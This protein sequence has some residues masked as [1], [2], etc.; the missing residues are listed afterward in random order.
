MRWLYK[1]KFKV[2]WALS[3]FIVKFAFIMPYVYFSLF[4]ALK[5]QNKFIPLMFYYALMM[6]VALVCTV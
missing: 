3:L 6:I 5:F 2:L 1:T 4:W